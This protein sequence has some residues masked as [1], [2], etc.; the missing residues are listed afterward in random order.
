MREDEMAVLA[1]EDG[2]F[3]AFRRG[4]RGLRE[5]DLPLTSAMEHVERIEEA[6][7]EAFGKPL[8]AVSDFPG[9]RLC[10]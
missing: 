2:A 7:Q 5:R 9:T 8:P 1:E 6:Y 3:P 10:F 4:L